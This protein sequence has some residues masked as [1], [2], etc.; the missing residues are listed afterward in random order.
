ML[1]RC[2][3]IICLIATILAFVLIGLIEQASGPAYSWKVQSTVACVFEHPRACA[4]A[5]RQPI[6]G[7]R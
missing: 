3:T 5:H 6:G 4:I 7:T 2:F 1:A